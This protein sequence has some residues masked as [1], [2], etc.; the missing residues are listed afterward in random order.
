MT[1]KRDAHEWPRST[2]DFLTVLQS[3]APWPQRSAR[4]DVATAPKRALRTRQSLEPYPPRR[5]AA[6]YRGLEPLRSKQLGDVSSRPSP[7]RSGVRNPSIT[8][9]HRLSKEV[10]SGTIMAI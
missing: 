5:T 3:H 9:A 6:R 10:P 1:Y 7:H 2:P 4:L 8:K